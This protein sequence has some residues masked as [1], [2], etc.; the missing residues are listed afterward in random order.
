MLKA[1]FAYIVMCVLILKDEVRKDKN[2]FSEINQ[3]TLH[4]LHC[5]TFVL[6]SNHMHA[7]CSRVQEDI[8]FQ[9]HSEQENLLKP[10]NI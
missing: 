2:K 5:P 1:Q 9:L 10:P 3:K 8:C 6:S 7:I 4:K